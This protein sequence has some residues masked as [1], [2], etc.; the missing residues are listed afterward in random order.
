MPKRKPPKDSRKLRWTTAGPD[1]PIY[2]EPV[3]IYKPK[4]RLNS[5]KREERED[6]DGPA[7]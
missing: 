7:D 5:A 6:D 3:T 4:T 2:R 1:D